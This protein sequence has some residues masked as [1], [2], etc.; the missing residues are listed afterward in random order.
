MGK[1]MPTALY[2]HKTALGLEKIGLKKDDKLALI[3]DN[4]PEM[5]IVSISAQAIPATAPPR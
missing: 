3:T 4:I 2:V 5:L 1:L